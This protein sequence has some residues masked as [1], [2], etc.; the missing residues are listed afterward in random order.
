MNILNEL[1][2][3]KKIFIRA[4][5]IITGNKGVYCKKGKNN[6][7]MEGTIL[8]EACTIGSYNYFAPYTLAYNAVIGNYCS[9]GPGCRIGLANHDMHAVSTMAGIN[10]GDEN[11]NLFDYQ[12]PTIIGS[13]VWLGANVVIKQGVT[14]GDGAVVGANAVVS[15]D[16]PAYAI[17]VGIPAKVVAYRFNEQDREILLKSKWFNLDKKEARSCV[18][19]I[20]KQLSNER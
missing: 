8:Y 7:V 2:M 4:I 5:R 19:N 12:N 14:I 20:R 18:R 11:M 3:Y 15:H 1:P 16:I 6:R 9:I 13:D 10:N 17:V